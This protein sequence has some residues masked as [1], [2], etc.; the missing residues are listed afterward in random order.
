MASVHVNTVTRDTEIWVDDPVVLISKDGTAFRLSKDR[1]IRASP[2]FADMLQGAQPGDDVGDLLD[3]YPVVRLDDDAD[4]LRHFLRMVINDNSAV[5]GRCYPFATVASATLIAHKYQAD[6]LLEDTCLDKAF[7][8]SL[9]SRQWSTQWK[10][11]EFGGIGLKVRPQDV[12]A[13]VNLA[14]TLNKKKWLPLALFVCCTGGAAAL[15]NG[16]AREDGNRAPDG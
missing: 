15:R 6:K 5:E 1:L 16:V 9:L 8:Y 13:V 2:V 12:F 4:G 10:V 3:G 7:T 11:V 14:H